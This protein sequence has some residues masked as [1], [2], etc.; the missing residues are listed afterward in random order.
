MKENQQQNKIRF[1]DHP[2]VKVPVTCTRN[3]TLTNPSK[4]YI[5][6]FEYQN[7]RKKQTTTTTTTTKSLTD[8]EQPKC[9]EIRMYFQLENH[10]VP[11]P[12]RCMPFDNENLPFGTFT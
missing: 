6:L 2:T 11:S 10:N 5:D 1:L 9:N 8:T 12:C 7:E 4:E 3:Y